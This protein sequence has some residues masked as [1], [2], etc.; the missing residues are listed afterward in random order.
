L[1]D[2]AQTRFDLLLDQ[3]ECIVVRFDLSTVSSRV[4]LTAFMNTLLKSHLVLS[5]FMLTRVP[6]CWNRESIEGR[7]DFTMR[8]PWVPKLPTGKAYDMVGGG[9]PT[10]THVPTFSLKDSSTWTIGE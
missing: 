9:D 10:S 4:G 2:W 3:R 5:K 1:T 8:P 6:E 7:V